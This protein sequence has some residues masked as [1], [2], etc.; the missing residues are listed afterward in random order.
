LLHK[1]SVLL[2]ISCVARISSSLNF[3]D[4][5]CMYVLV[6]TS[7]ARSAINSS[8]AGN[9]T[10][11]LSDQT[12]GPS[13]PTPGPSDPTPESAAVSLS[14]IT[15]KMAVLPLVSAWTMR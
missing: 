13:D 3:I 5:A 4:C 10:P 14:H 7:N 1:K 2:W 9:I 15:L 6:V 11:G 8:S 12:P